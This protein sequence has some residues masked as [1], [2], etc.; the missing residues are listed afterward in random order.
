MESMLEHL[1]SV[2]RTLGPI[3]SIKE[4]WE[5]KGGEKGEKDNTARE[6]VA[7][8]GCSLSYMGSWGRGIASSHEFETSLNDRV[9]FCPSLTKPKKQ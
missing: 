8:S 4:K 9:A 3:I 1:A 7:C 5:G 2:H 6:N